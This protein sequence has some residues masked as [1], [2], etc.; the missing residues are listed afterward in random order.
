M[1]SL[2]KRLTLRLRWWK[3]RRIKNQHSWYLILFLRCDTDWD[4]RFYHQNNGPL[5]TSN[6]HFNNQ[7]SNSCIS[8]LFAASVFQ[9]IVSDSY[10]SHFLLVCHSGRKVLQL[11][12]IGFAVNHWLTCKIMK[13]VTG[14]LKPNWLY[15]FQ[16]Q[17][18]GETYLAHQFLTLQF[19]IDS[20]WNF[21]WTAITHQRQCL[22]IRDLFCYR[23][24]N[25]V[26]RQ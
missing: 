4:H 8:G 24:S 7:R 5:T 20:I 11:F 14:T 23:F 13:T 1:L 18:L 6:D 12:L 10:L 3:T 22:S 26:H 2:S 19:Y 21:N 9:L 15:S 17:F 16:R 25:S